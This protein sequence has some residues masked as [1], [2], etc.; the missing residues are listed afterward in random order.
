MSGEFFTLV[1]EAQIR[2]GIPTI[3]KSLPAKAGVVGCDF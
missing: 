1:R 3:M 2:I